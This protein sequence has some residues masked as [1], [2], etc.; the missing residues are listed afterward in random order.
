MA[1][2]SDKNQARNSKHMPRPSDSAKNTWFICRH[3]PG[4]PQKHAVVNH[5]TKISVIFRKLT[6]LNP[7]ILNISRLTSS[8]MVHEAASSRRMSLRVNEGRFPGPGNLRIFVRMREIRFVSVRR[9]T[10]FAKWH[11]LPLKIRAYRSINQLFE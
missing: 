6:C 3:A 8:R 4:N 2:S 7:I 1:V 5:P 11:S 10:L 9:S